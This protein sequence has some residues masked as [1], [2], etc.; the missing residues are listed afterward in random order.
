MDLSEITPDAAIPMMSL[1]DDGFDD[2]SPVVRVMTGSMISYLL[3]LG[4][5]SEDR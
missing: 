3:R 1:G 4:D 2:E 5:E